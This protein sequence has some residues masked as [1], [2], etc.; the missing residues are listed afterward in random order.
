M[1][2]II[3]KS[4]CFLLTGL[5]LCSVLAGCGKS[6][7]KSGVNDTET[8]LSAAQEYMPL[9]QE[10]NWDVIAQNAAYTLLFD[11]TRCAVRV[12]NNADGTVWDSNPTEEELS[13]VIS[14]AVQDSYRS[15]V[16]LE[17]YDKREKSTLLESYKDAVQKEQMEVFSV[18]P[19][20]C[21]TFFLY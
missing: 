10:D 8:T 6:D 1:P 11:K 20:H 2:N 18:P 15:Q 17:Y 5:M 3:K 14:E 19:G 13:G 7:S 16:I 4:G 21:S 12:K 9:S